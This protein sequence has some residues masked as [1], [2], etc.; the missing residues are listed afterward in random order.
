MDSISLELQLRRVRLALETQISHP[1]LEKYIPKPVIDN[2]KLMILT[3]LMNTTDLPE[4]K[5]DHYIITTM[6]VQIALD[7]HDLVANQSAEQESL[8]YKKKRQ[9]TVLAGDYYSGLYYYLLSKLDDVAMI[10][11]L[12]SAIKEINELKMVAYYNKPDTIQDWMRTVK[13]I[14]SL[15]IQRVAEQIQGTEINTLS[16]EWLLMTR[17]TKEKQHVL[18]S[19]Q[20]L[21]LDV[22]TRHELAQ[23]PKKQAVQLMEGAIQKSMQKM[24]TAVNQLPLKFH[25]LTTYVHD[26]LNEYSRKN[27]KV[28]EEG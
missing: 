9:L 10:H 3:S 21:L 1:Y 4:S 26:L 16:E 18:S 25:Q 15:L 22:M 24:E 17:L 8:Q 19:G 13:Q 28:V 20:S 14:E 23:N 5:K 12:A 7:T 6:L 2:D 27:T 11:V